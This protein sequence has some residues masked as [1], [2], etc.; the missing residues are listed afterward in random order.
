[1]YIFGLIRYSLDFTIFRVFKNTLKIFVSPYF[2]FL[3]MSMFPDE[4][5]EQWDN[6]IKTLWFERAALR[7]VFDHELDPVF[8]K[9]YIELT[10]QLKKLESTLP[11]DLKHEDVRKKEDISMFTANESSKELDQEDCN[12]DDDDDD[13]L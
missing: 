5:D 8:Q 11:L 1:M 7:L 2:Y 3:I 6:S 4:Y 10:E 13:T 12:D 9:Q